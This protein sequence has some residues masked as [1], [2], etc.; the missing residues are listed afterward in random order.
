M[1]IALAVDLAFNLPQLLQ[2]QVP[3]YPSDLQAQVHNSELVNGEPAGT[4]TGS[5]RH[6]E[7]LTASDAWS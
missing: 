6:T 7:V 5:R 3:G 4:I 2:H 1:R